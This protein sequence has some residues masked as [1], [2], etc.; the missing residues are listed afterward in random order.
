MLGMS[1][2]SP[3]GPGWARTSFHSFGDFSL[4][5]VETA[6]FQTLKLIPDA[7]VGNILGRVTGGT[8]SNIFGT[9]D[10]ATYYPSANLFLMNPSGFLFGPNATVNVGGMVAFTSADYLRLDWTDNARFQRD[11][12]RKRAC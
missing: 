2:R 3:V 12:Q 10:S 1:T 5:A 11:S 9:I 8:P 7:T 4:A 6:R